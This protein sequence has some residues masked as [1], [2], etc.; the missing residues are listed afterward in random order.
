MKLVDEAYVFGS[1]PNALTSMKPLD[2]REEFWG[3]RIAPQSTEVFDVYAT[4]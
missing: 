1:V 3:F 2:S 4:V